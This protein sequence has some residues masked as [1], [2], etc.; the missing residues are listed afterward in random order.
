MNKSIDISATDLQI[1]QS[2]LKNI[3]P[4]NTKVWVFGSRAKGTTRRS[5]DLDLA[6]EA[7]SPLTKKESSQL[8]HAFK[9]SDLCYKVDIVVYLE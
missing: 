9:A 5:S 7:K 8:F 4:E 2:I 3:L 6:I 1:V